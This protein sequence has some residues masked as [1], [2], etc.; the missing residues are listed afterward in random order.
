MRSSACQGR[1]LEWE[2]KKTAG[3]AI[4]L[5]DQQKMTQ[6]PVRINTENVWIL[7]AS[8]NSSSWLIKIFFCRKLFLVFCMQMRR[9]QNAT[10]WKK[11]KKKRS[12]RFAYYGNL[13]GCWDD[14]VLLLCSPVVLGR[15]LKVR[16]QE[17]RSISIPFLSGTHSCACSFLGSRSPE[18]RFPV[19]MTIPGISLFW[20]LTPD[21]MKGPVFRSGTSPSAG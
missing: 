11:K 14:F 15:G 8:D 18:E 13:T 9:T 17:V 12:V 20:T 6:H 16:F 4:V 5:R 21:K 1:S 2:M 3:F 7:S 19:E 10:W